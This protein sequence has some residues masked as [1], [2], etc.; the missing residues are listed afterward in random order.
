[1]CRIN[2][3]HE[4]ECA[5]VHTLTTPD[6]FSLVSHTLLYD[7]P[8][9]IR[10]MFSAVGHEVV[11]LHRHTIGGLTLEGLGEGEWRPVSAAD[12]QVGLGV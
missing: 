10:R 11:T 5:A 4:R 3:A 1:M 7:L 2:M 8:P 9:Q 12:I 6:F